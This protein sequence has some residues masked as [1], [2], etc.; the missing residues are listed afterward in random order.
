MSRLSHQKTFT[1]NNPRA[2]AEKRAETKISQGYWVVKKDWSNEKTTDPQLEPT[3]LSK[4]EIKAKTQ[5]VLKK[6]FP[7]VAEDWVF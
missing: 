6:Y 5:E 7:G 2:D 3:P 4:R 1:S